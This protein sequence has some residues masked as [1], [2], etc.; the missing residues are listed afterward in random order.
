MHHPLNTILGTIRQDYARLIDPEFV[1]RACRDAGHRW[2][3][4]VLSPGAV[5]HWFLVQV[6]YGNTAV[7]HLAILAERAFTGSANCQ[8]RALLPRKVIQAVLR[9]LVQ[10]LAPIHQDK[11]RWRGHRTWLV[12]GSS[13]S[14]SDTPELQRH[15]GQ[16][17]GQAPGRGFPVAKVLALFHAGTGMLMEIVPSRLRSHGMSAISQVHPLFGTDGIPV[18]DRGFCQYAHLSM[19]VQSGVFAVFRVHQR[20]IVDFTPHRRAAARGRASASSGRSRSRWVRGLGSH[21]QVVEWSKPTVR[22]R[23]MSPDE[24]ANLPDVL[25][26]REL[27][28]RVGPAGYRSHE[29][30]LATT[31]L[32]AERYPLEALADL[33]KN[34]WQ[35]ELYLRSLSNST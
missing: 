8:A 35:V 22:P 1:E 10:R 29:V 33:Y 16:P 24:Y 31:L 14:T 3:R 27:R 18:G 34:R 23:W 32:D 13:F 12:D 28:Y 15:F 30:T 17:G 20:Q 19:L 9:N 26:V 2:R 7:E 4:R 21:D 5:L 6:L 11:G 25:T